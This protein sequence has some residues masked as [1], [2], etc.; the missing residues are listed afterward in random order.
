MWRRD[1]GVLNQSPVT[2]RGPQTRTPTW[3]TKMAAEAEAKISGAIEKELD[4]IDKQCLRS[5]QV[6]K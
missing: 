2:T 6:N 3:P 5:L 4:I 1:G